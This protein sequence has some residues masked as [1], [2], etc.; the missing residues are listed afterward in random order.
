MR[1]RLILLLIAAGFFLWTPHIASAAESPPALSVTDIAGRAVAFK[2]EPHRIICLG[3]GCLRLICYLGAQDR[4]VGVENFEKTQLWGRPYRYAAPSVLNLPVIG[5]GGPGNVN[6]EPDLEAVLKVK[7]DMIFATYMDA[8]KADALQKKIGVPVVLLSYGRF[9]SF[10]EDLYRSLRIAGRIFGHEKRAEEL[11]AFIN[12]AQKD[13]ARRTEGTAKDPK[14]GVY[15]GGIGYRGAQGVE[16]TETTYMPLEWI[17]GRNVAKEAGSG[18]V[19]IN[20]EQLLSWNPDIILLDALGLKVVATDYARKPDFYQALK[21]F[22]QKKVYVIWPF[23]S[24]T[25]NVGT[26]ILNAYVLGKLL[27]PARFKDIDI[28]R[29]ADEIYRF[30]VG[31]PVAAA[32]KKGYGE[33]GAVWAPQAAK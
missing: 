8:A 14:P 13:L 9:A 28:N 17:R 3:P 31:T 30:F 32:M 12:A 11:Q 10:D 24:Y 5:P 6:K 22:R 23:N 7:P 25:T 21:A 19:F 4:L 26:V 1:T 2:A 15:V 18:H 20:K 27:Y 29:K 16:S 33:P